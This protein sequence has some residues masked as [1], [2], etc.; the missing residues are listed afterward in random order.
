MRVVYMNSA[1]T[2][3]CRRKEGKRDDA[4][5]DAT[6]EMAYVVKTAGS[7]QKAKGTI[8]VTV[9]PIGELRDP[10]FKE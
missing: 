8:R 6:K 9:S 2:I 4:I 5:E 3:F 1:G 10:G 7:L